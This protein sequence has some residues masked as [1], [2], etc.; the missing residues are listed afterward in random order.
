MTKEELIKEL[1]AL[2]DKYETS[3]NNSRITGCLLEIDEDTW[4]EWDGEKLA[5]LGGTIKKESSQ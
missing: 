4:M 5:S 3:H 1:A 2:L